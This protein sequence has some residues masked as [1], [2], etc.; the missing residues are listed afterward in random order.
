MDIVRTLPL[1]TRYD[2]MCP[3]H[4]QR[5]AI[6]PIEVYRNGLVR[7]MVDVLCDGIVRRI[8]A[9]EWDRLRGVI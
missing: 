9:K 1:F 3:I 8:S 5:H 4:G 6:H 2:A 7:A